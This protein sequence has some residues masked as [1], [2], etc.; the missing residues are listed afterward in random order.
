[1]AE[2]YTI[3][4]IIDLKNTTSLEDIKNLLRDSAINLNCEQEYFTHETEGINNRIKRNN[5]IYVVEFSILDNVEKYIEFIKTV[6]KVK[7]ELV[8][9]RN[10]IMWMSKQ[11]DKSLDTNIVDREYIT[12]T[13]EVYK[14][15]NTYS[16][17]YKLLQNR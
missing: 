16:R 9:E 12:R 6:K 8:C 5:I 17:L 1:M 3:H 15:N 10:T 4:L 2:E 11:Y 7:I 14:C 13:I